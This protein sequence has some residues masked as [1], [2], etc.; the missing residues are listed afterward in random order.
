VITGSVLLVDLDIRL[1]EE[2][3]DAARVIAYEYPGLPAP[4]SPITPVT[5][6]PEELALN[7]AAEL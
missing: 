1:F 7:V 4:E 5:M 2:I 3:L 6:S